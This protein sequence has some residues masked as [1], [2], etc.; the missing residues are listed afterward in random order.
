MKIIL[1]FEKHDRYLLAKSDL[2]D[3]EMGINEL[4]LTVRYNDFGDE[5]IIEEYDIKDILRIESVR[6]YFGIYFS[7]GN[8]LELFSEE[9]RMEIRF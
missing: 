1:E 9:A 6:S 7:N 3:P 8:C 4:Y 5:I 2:E